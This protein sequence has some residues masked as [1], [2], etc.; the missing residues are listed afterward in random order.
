M[1]KMEWQD[2]PERSKFKPGPWLNEPD[3]IQWRDDATGLPCLMNRKGVWCGYVGVDKTSPLYEK[4]CS[5]IG[6]EFE[7]HGGLSYSDLAK[8]G[9]LICCGL[10]G[11]DDELWWLGFDCGH[12]M[13]YRSVVSDLPVFSREDGIYRDVVY[14]HGEV[15]NLAK[16]IVEVAQTVKVKEL[17][18]E[19]TRSLVKDLTERVESSLITYDRS[20]TYDLSALEQKQ[21]SEWVGTA[22]C[23]HL[24]DIDRWFED[25]S[26]ERDSLMERIK[27][28]TVVKETENQT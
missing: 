22:L 24:G 5:D 7:V 26:E 20:I 25:Y 18:K 2:H 4:S 28:A 9:G 14:V 1:D 19:I 21:F 13:D 8:A 12:Y 15:T 16:Q 27:N 17:V 6:G 10:E 11:E 23:A 3:R